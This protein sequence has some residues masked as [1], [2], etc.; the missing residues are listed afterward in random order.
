[1]T[2][3]INGKPY[4]TESASFPFER[5]VEV[6]NEL[7]EAAGVRISGNPSI[8]YERPGDHG[9]VLLPGEAVNAVDG[10][11]FHVDVGHWG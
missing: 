10:T 11:R 6:Y 3:Y 5:L 9:H 4:E 2:I 8:D 1:M 7:H